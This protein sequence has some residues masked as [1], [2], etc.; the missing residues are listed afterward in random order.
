MNTEDLAGGGKMG[1]YILQKS[2]YIVLV[3]IH[4]ISKSLC[5]CDPIIK[6]PIPNISNI[7]ITVQSHIGGRLLIRLHPANINVWGSRDE[8]REDP[9]FPL[10]IAHWR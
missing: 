9:S 4:V 8:E 2:T 3:P 7:K 5:E 10:A 1:R 6:G